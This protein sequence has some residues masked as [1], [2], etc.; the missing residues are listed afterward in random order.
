MMIL[1]VYLGGVSLLLAA[2]VLN[3][4]ARFL[5]LASWYDVLTDSKWSQLSLFDWGWLTVIYPLGLGVIL[6]LVG[7]WVRV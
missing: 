7:G 1:K 6:Y 5:G 4:L 2:I 3:S